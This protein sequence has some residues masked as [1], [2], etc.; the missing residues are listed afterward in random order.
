MFDFIIIG[1]GP[2]GSLLAW[3]LAKKNYQ[4]CL[5]ERSNNKKIISNPYV[6]NCSFDYL[7]LYSNKIGGNSALW[8]NKI[9]LISKKEFREKLWGFKYK[10]L[11]LYSNKLEK[12][13][14]I[15]EKKIKIFQK[16]KLNI[17]QSI[18]FNFN[19]IFEFLSIKNNKNI[20]IIRE[21]SII[22]I[23]ENKTN[24]IKEIQIK[25][26]SG[27]VKNIKLKKAI[28]LCAGGLGN[29]HLIL[30]LFNKSKLKKT[31]LADHPHIK[32]GDL[33][34]KNIDHLKEFKKYY[35]NKNI[36]EK[37]L[38]F[39]KHNLYAVTQIAVFSSEDYVR[40]YL[41]KIHK[42]NFFFYKTI[43]ILIMNFYFY[44]YKF[45]NLLNKL[46]YSKK[47]CL[48]F[49][50]SQNK[51]SGKIQLSN[52]KDIYGLKKINIHW[53]IST[54][55]RT[56]YKN[57]IRFIFYKLKLPRVK[58]F[59]DFA[60]NVYVGQHPSCSTPISRKKN[61]IT[62]DK[63]LKLKSY[64]NVYSLGSNVFPE[65]GFTNPTWTIMTLGLKLMDHLVNK[66]F[67]K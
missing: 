56:K 19:N 52:A 1:T 31:F 55:E 53:K 63:N 41:K 30:N 9:F 40:K 28:I 5:I 15:P 59:N 35:L 4:I 32:I 54:S 57:L 58:L 66:R 26:V 25:N 44:F 46:I 14:N 20:H 50:F 65:N 11:K 49:S 48:E 34:K 3:L 38:F 36:I 6:N 42:S 2:A 47:F 10:I 13:L 23:L 51:K 61:G 17:S 60:K 37:N 7:P 21:Y 24:S 18:R 64:N 39:K 12:I 29:T 43:N 67:G 8:H 27:K 45:F 33:E 62:V 22:N 16:N